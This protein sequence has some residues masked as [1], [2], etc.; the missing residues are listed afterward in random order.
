MGSKSRARRLFG[1]RRMGEDAQFE[2]YLGE[3]DDWVPL[4]TRRGKKREKDER[5]LPSLSSPSVPPPLY[6]HPQAWP[7]E[8]GPDRHARRRR[9]NRPPSSAA[10]GGREVDDDHDD[11]EM[12]DDE[13]VPEDR[14]AQIR[15]VLGCRRMDGREEMS[16]RAVCPEVVLFEQTKKVA[17]ISLP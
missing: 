4:Q 12:G 8:E 1:S 3:E 9:E 11:R 7:T 2:L 13:V 6:T 10:D 16:E 15:Q 5:L 17:H 14:A